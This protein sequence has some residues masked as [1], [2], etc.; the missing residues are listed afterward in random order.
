MCKATGFLR[1]EG[2]GRPSDS[3]AP[4]PAVWMYRWASEV[5]IGRDGEG[6]TGS[7]G[8]GGGGTEGR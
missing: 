3:V 7:C 4:P 1:E 8:S 2:A 6:S 5:V